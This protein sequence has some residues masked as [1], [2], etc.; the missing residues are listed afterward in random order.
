MLRLIT[1]YPEF[2]ETCPGGRTD[3]QPSNGDAHV[4]RAGREGVVLGLRRAGAVGLVDYS[5]PVRVVGRDFNPVLVVARKL[6]HHFRASQVAGRTQVD[7]PPVTGA[8]IGGTPAR[9]RVAIVTICSRVGALGA[10]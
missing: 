9:G 4:A 8:A 7:L 5:R 6:P 3:G 2:E 1:K 10:I